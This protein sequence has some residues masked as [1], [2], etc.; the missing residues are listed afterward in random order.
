MGENFPNDF[1]HCAHEPEIRSSFAGR[2]ALD[3]LPAITL[4]SPGAEGRG[5]EDHLEFGYW[6][7]FGVWDLELPPAGSWKGQGVR[8]AV[9]SL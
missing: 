8:G 3:P 1:A 9:A 6:S 2:D 7:F 4:S 5:D